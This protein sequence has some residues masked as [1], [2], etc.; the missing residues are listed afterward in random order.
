MALPL[1]I[2]GG[3]AVA[4]AFGGKKA[5]DGYQKKSAADDCLEKAKKLE[6]YHK[7]KLERAERKTNRRLRWLGD[8][9]LEIGK[10]LNEFHA[11]AEELLKELNEEGAEKR[12][13]NIPRHQLNKIQRLG[14]S[15]TE[16]LGTM[17]ASGVSGAAVSFAVYSGVMALGAA[18][19]GTPIAALSGAAAY[20][21]TMAA[22]GGGSLA[23]G[24]MGIAGGTMVLGS[25]AVAPLI[26]IGGWAYDKHATKALEHARQCSSNVEQAVRKM[27]IALEHLTEVG[28]YA[29]KIFDALSTMRT[30]FIERYFEP[31]KSIHSAVMMNRKNGAS[32]GIGD[33]CENLLLLIENGY[34]LA[35]IMTNIITTPLFKVRKQENGELVIKDN[36]IEME[37]DDNG[38][39]VINKDELDDVLTSSDVKFDKLSSQ[40]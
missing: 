37:T 28:C 38:M 4:A 34:M 22:L 21:A 32:G 23:A 25:A 26:A 27:N 15:A 39:N 11:V 3:A 1:V 10:D 5:Y 8:K 24:G 9:E 6:N 19:T 30:V 12:E 31:L 18:S 29:A 33:S 20:N 40:S 17:I 36:V 35:S 7:E 2:L 16:Y 14:A 13:L